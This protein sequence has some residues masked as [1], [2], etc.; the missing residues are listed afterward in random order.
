MLLRLHK[1]AAL[2]ALFTIAVIAAFVDPDAWLQ[3]IKNKTPGTFANLLQLMMTALTDNMELL[4]TVLAIA[5]GIA[6][7][8]VSRLVAAAGQL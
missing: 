3:S 1:K 4:T 5:D 7:N 2:L 6:K 8:A